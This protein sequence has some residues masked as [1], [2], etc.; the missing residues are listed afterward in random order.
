MAL[1]FRQVR[2]G[3]R[4]AALSGEQGIA[5]VLARAEQLIED[6][7]EAAALV[8]DGLPQHIIGQWYARK[9]RVAPRADQVF[10]DLEEADAEIAWQLRHALRA[11]EVQA[12]LVHLR[13]LY[14]MV[15][16]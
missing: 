5:D 14:R 6:D 3:E 2:D 1:S 4:F 10:A 16:S 13:V 9:H 8:L 12:R 11:P 7:E 15:R